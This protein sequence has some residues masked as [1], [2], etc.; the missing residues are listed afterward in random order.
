M[1]GNEARIHRYLIS[2][3]SNNAESALPTEPSD[4]QLVGVDKVRNSS[5]PG[6][7]D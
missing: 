7:L 2:V 1:A 6:V 5:E 3:V 4:G